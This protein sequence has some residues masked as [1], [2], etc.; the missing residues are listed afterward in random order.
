MVKTFGK[1]NFMFMRM[2]PDS[3]GLQTWG[4]KGTYTFDE[5]VLTETID[6]WEW[7]LGGYPIM[8]NI[9][10]K[11]D[12]MIQKGPINTAELPSGWEDV[13]LYEVYLRVE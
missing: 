11:G 8:Y 7:D 9:E 10:F 3:A 1:R 13:K 2:F 4:A 6:Y 12:S 5:G